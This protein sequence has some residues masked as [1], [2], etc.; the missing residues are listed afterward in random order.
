MARSQMQ[1]MQ[2]GDALPSVGGTV[3]EKGPGSR[4]RTKL[5]PRGTEERSSSVDRFRGGGRDAATGA[6]EEN[7]TH[8]PT[9]SREIH[10]DR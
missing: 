3:E 5:R 4:G 6:Q 1:T 2:V 8:V 7:I 10:V 9:T